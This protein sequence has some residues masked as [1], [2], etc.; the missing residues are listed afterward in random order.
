V[1]ACALAAVDPLQLGRVPGLQ[2]GLP[3]FVQLG[4]LL[5]TF[6]L[7]ML[8]PLDTGLYLRFDM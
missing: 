7:L 6:G 2:A 5:G 3:R 1:H 4:T 8:H